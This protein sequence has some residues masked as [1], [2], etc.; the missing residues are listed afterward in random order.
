MHVRFLTIDAFQFDHARKSHWQYCIH[1]TSL[2]PRSD[3]LR[4]EELDVKR[5]IGIG[6]CGEHRPYD[7]D[8]RLQRRQSPPV[9]KQGASPSRATVRGRGLQ[10]ARLPWVLPRPLELERGDS[11]REAVDNHDHVPRPAHTRLLR[12]CADFPIVL[13]QPTRWVGRGADVRCPC[14]QR[15]EEVARVKGREC[16]VCQG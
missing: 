8:A 15:L 10:M 12:T 11:A 2:F 16:V 13:P 7:P 9:N 5:P 6:M 1:S 3:G 4:V 14:V